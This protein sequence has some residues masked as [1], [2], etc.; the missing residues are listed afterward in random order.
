MI[1]SLLAPRFAAACSLF[2][3][4]ATVAVIVLTVTMN[5]DV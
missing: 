3:L 5:T 4:I 2:S 1:C